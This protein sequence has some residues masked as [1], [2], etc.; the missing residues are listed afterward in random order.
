M[1]W[2][3]L[4]HA[5]SIQP[6]LRGDLLELR[7]LRAEDFDGLFAVA[8]D[9]LVW[10]QH[11][12]KDRHE[13]DAFRSF[14]REQ[15][16]SGGTL[17]AV[18]RADGSIVGSSRFH[19]YDEATSE[20]EIG[21]TFLAR[22]HWGGVY[23]R[24]MKRLMLRHAFRFVDN[25][26]FLVDPQNVRSQRAVEKIGAVRFGSRLDA[27]GRD[28]VAYRI[29][30]ATF[31]ADGRGE[32]EA[33]ARK[34]EPR[35]RLLR[36]WAMAGG[37]SAQVSGLEIE[38]ADGRTE[39]LVVRRHGAADLRRNPHV[40]ADEFKLLQLLQS[41]GLP[42]PAPRCLSTPCLVVDYVEGEPG[43]AVAH[44]TGF[45]AWDLWADGRLAGRI[46]EWGLDEAAEAAMWAGHEAFVVQALESVA[47][48]R[49]AT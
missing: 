22:S 18:D 41:A 28:S 36:T 31:A 30:A 23:N 39:K 10:E 1:Q 32:L 33:L 19:A 25:V 42:V 2:L 27:G 8:A 47:R 40:A 12:V 35:S 26:V 49:R 16:E 29:S 13:E 17:V 11:P 24:E 7:P 37:V 21:W 44:E 14:F 43:P 20:L 6:V 34:V 38:T 5:P 15:L 45:V 9:P 48:L 4:A 3:R 46:A